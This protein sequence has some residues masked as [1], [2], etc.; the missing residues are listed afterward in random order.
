MVGVVLRRGLWLLSESW[1]EIQLA[2]G[3]AVRLP[4]GLAVRLP[5]GLAATLPEGLAVRL[6]VGLAVVRLPEGLAA[7]LPV[8]LA[9]RLQ[10]IS[11]STAALTLAAGGDGGILVAG[12]S[13]LI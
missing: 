10:P 6:P 7:R 4:E 12:P 2:L 1:L 5:V 9:V 3:L 11:A 8:E 13:C